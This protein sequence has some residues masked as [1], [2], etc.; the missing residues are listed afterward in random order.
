MAG[1]QR[2]SPKVFSSS[3][4]CPWAGMTRAWQHQDA[5]R[6]SSL[7]SVSFLATARST[8]SAATRALVRPADLP[9]VASFS[10]TPGGSERE[11]VL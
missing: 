11:S 8:I 9:S 10:T 1:I 5:C 3:T 2:R 7:S 4:S 6:V